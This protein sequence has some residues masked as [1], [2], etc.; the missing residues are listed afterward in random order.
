MYSTNRKERLSK[1]RSEIDTTQRQLDKLHEERHTLEMEQKREDF[2]CTCVK[3]NKDVEIY[4][5]NEQSRRGRNPLSCGGFVAD[6][7]SAREDCGVCLG[8]GVPRKHTHE[9]EVFMPDSCPACKYQ[10]THKGQ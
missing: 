6:T 9:S 1:I 4:D 7:L 10:H 3:L 2:P 5:M 8:T